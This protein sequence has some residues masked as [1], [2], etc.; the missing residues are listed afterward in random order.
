M[1]YS[2]CCM[3]YSESADRSR[4]PHRLQAQTPVCQISGLL[5]AGAYTVSG[6]FVQFDTDADLEGVSLTEAQV[7]RL[8]SPKPFQPPA[9]FGRYV[10]KAFKRFSASTHF[11]L[12]R[13]K[14]LRTLTSCKDLYVVT[15]K[16]GEAWYNFITGMWD[17]EGSLHFYQG[18]DH[19]L[20][21]AATPLTGSDKLFCKLGFSHHMDHAIVRYIEK[22]LICSSW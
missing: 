16:D 5:E 17:P 8:C 20:Y 14:Q 11:C 15:T 7:A 10:Q 3:S 18:R 13:S 22:S 9:H 2:E 12:R 21:L 19:V 1:S 4:S 6:V